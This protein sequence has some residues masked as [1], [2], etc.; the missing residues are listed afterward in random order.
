MIPLCQE[1]HWR[2]S[3][4]HLAELETLKIKILILSLMTDRREGCLA[5]IFNITSHWGRTPLVC[6]IE[7][8]N[9]LMVSWLA[10]VKRI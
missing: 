3:L 5:L 8:R 9:V 4:S 7:N 6:M 10:Y 1:S 2:E